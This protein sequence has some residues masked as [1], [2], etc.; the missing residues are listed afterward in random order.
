MTTPGV[1]NGVH[2]ICHVTD[3]HDTLA[4]RSYVNMQEQARTTNTRTRSPNDAHLDE[5]QQRAAQQLTAG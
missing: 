2:R 5:P 4:Q 3:V 1:P